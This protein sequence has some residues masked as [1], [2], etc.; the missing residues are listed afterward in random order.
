MPIRI[1][2]SF[3]DADPGSYT[4]WKIRNF[5]F[6]L[7]HQLTLLYL[8]RQRHRLI[9][10][11]GCILCVLTNSS[12]CCAQGLPEMLLRQ[13]EYEDPIVRGG[14]HLFHSTFFRE[15]CSWLCFSDNPPPPPPDPD[16]NVI[17]G[18][19]QNKMLTQKISAKNFI[20]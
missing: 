19:L 12:C 1:R 9:M 8:S 14:K 20:L 2:C 3:C 18:S 15:P 7:I 16:A 4:C 13:Y 5:S 10:L 17:L 11:R 6:T